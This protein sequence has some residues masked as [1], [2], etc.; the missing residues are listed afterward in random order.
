MFSTPAYM[1]S[2]PTECEEIRVYFDKGANILSIIAIHSTKLG[3]AIGGCRYLNYSSFQEALNDAEKLAKSM[4]YKAA[5]ANVDFGGGKSVIIKQP[6]NQDPKQ[7]FKKFGMFVDSLKGRYVTA[8]DSGTTTSHMKIISKSTPFVAGIKG[9]NPSYFTA[10][11]VFRAMC[12]AV[13]HKFG[14]TSLRGIRIAI[15]GAGNVGYFLSHLLSQDKASIY[16]ADTDASKSLKIAQDFSAHIIS[17]KEVISLPC[18]IFSPCAL[19]GEIN[20]TSVSL[21]KANIIA[22]AANNQLENEEIAEIL[23]EKEIL[24]CP[25]YLINSGGLIYVA[26]LYKGENIK[27]VKNKVY[28]LHDAVSDILKISQ[29]KKQTPLR[30]SNN[31]VEKKLRK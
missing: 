8:I 25:D 4:S 16:I 13:K 2:S 27:N 1:F 28:Q 9:I 10:L 14:A 21:L 7:T 22:G 29:I 30:I 17:P 31:L 24:Y 15:Q 3:P 6:S 23:A 18:E 11:G 19:G 5:L 12:A 20:K 26:N